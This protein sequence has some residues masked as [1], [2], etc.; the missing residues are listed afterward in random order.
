MMSLST[1][2]VLLVVLVLLV[3]YAWVDY[4]NKLYA[5]IA[6]AILASLIGS[7]MAVLVF[8]GAVQTNSGTQVSDMP[9]A[10]VLLFISIVI[11]VYAFFMAMEAKEEY[12]AAQ[13]QL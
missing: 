4:R 11:G 1:F 2:N 9:T 12:E 13:E 10:S 8:I 5:N 6:A 7:L 3:I